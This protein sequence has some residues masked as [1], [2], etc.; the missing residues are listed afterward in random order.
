ML[1]RAPS[2]DRVSLNPDESQYEATASYFLAT[3]KSPLSYALGEPGAF[4]L[5][6]IV[7]RVFGPYAMFQFRLIVQLVCLGLAWTLYW[8]VRRETDR[9]CGLAAGLVFLHYGMYY[10]GLTVNRE[11]FAVLLIT[12]GLALW[13]AAAGRPGARADGVRLL[14]GLATGLALWFKLQAAP[15]VLVV[16][17][18]L[19]WRSVET[20]RTGQAWRELALFG[21]GVAVAGIGH[22]LPYWSAGSLRQFLGDVLRDY[23]VYVVGHE[24]V[25]RE[26][27]GGTLRLYLRAFLTAQPH[28][29]LLLAAY[30]IAGLAVAQALRWA[31]RPVGRRPFG[32]RP[33]VLACAAWLGLSMVS[34]QLGHRFFAHY[35]LLL[36]PPL[37]AL[38]GFALH[39][40]WREA[41]ARRWARAAA[42]LFVAALSLDALLVIAPGVP[43]LAHPDFPRA[44]FLAVHAAAAAG[45]LAYC[46]VRPLTRAPRVAAA[47]LVLEIALL[48]GV[49]QSTPTPLSMSHNP[50]SFAELAAFLRGA[51]A[52][53]DRLF[54]WGWAPEIYSLTRLEAASQVVTSEYVVRDSVEARERPSLDPL[55]V[56]RMMRDL[57]EREPRF[58]VDASERS[59]SNTDARFYRLALY[60]GFELVELLAER[61][62]RRARID[63]CVV[64]ERRSGGVPGA[65]VRID[66]PAPQSAL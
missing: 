37:S 50:H 16:P 15:A 56:E 35:Y 61:Y 27:S 22:L 18:V 41:P 7:G 9:W 38:C 44:L 4:A 58:I 19:L 29:P 40:L 30:G 10:E 57:R 6:T 26:A 63:G 42:L 48:V 47:W 39:W 46:L 5:Y 13:L 36:L 8:I 28:R 14:A 17:V 45:L 1:L 25:V 54:V 64:Y 65:P 3:G 31:W 33:A 32:A 2:L 51:A 23:N 62:V 66:R 53:G 55:W 59:W 20:R 11:W 12:T 52:P 34:V 21:A 43:L 49:Q 24:Q 60:P